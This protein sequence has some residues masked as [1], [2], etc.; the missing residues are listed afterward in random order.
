MRLTSASSPVESTRLGSDWLKATRLKL[1]LGLR[2]VAERLDV[3]PQA[4]HQ[5]EK[6]ETAGTISLRQLENVAHA[7]GCRVVYALVPAKAARPTRVARAT[8]APLAVEPAPVEPHSVERS[9][10]LENL[11]ADRFD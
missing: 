11:A 5:F 7:M 8:P 4:V 1:G 2:Q 3:S 6:S 10:F 9:L